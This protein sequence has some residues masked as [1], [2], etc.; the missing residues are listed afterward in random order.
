[1]TTKTL[2][3]AALFAALPAVAHADETHRHGSL[4][5]PNFASRDLVGV[6]ERGTYNGSS[7]TS[8]TVTCAAMDRVDHHQDWYDVDDNGGSWLSSKHA[9]EM[10]VKIDSIVVYGRDLS[11]TQPFSCYVFSTWENNF[12]SWGPRKYTCSQDGGCPDSTTE[13][14]GLATLKFDFDP[15]SNQY[16]GYHHGVVCTIPATGSSGTSYVKA[17]GTFDR[18]REIIHNVIGGQWNLFRVERN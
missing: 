2:L 4:C 10:A 18:A 16:G 5:A 6:D 12:S 11:A 3:L 17:I 13:Y 8:A 15:Y 7:S 1:M 14:T 9:R